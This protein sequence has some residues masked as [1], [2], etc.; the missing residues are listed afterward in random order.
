MGFQTQEE[1]DAYSEWLKDQM[2]GM[3]KHV[4]DSDLFT[5]EVMGHAVWTLPHRLFI[6]KAWPQGDEARSFWIISGEGLP[7]DHVDGAMAGT[8]RESARHFSMKWQLQS[9]QLEKLAETG[10]DK[11]SGVD[12][13][14]VSARLQQQAEGLYQLVEREDM[15]KTTEGPLVQGNA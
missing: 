14:S 11:D 10:G 1:L 2:R 4:Q 13:E 12:W 15:W 6:G 8:A 7:T 5:E 9:A 3:V